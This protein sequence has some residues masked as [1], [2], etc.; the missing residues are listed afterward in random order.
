V[1]CLFHLSVFLSTPLAVGPAIGAFIIRHP[2]LDLGSS[3]LR[4]GT[5]K[6]VTSVFYTAAFCSFLN[7]LLVLFVFPESLNSKISPADLAVSATAPGE[8]EAVAK[9]SAWGEFV[10]GFSHVAVVFS[11]KWKDLPSGGRRRDWSLTLL[12]T[13]LFGYLLASVGS[14]R[15]A[16]FTG[17][18][19]LGAGYIPD[20][21]LVRGTRIRV[22]L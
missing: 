6:T 22:G 1:V 2:I 15:L 4:E 21:V 17:A 13:A 16:Q 11:P 5:G 12:A 18:D 19:P 14:E 8:G 20:Q 7:L 10:D 9:K 3:A